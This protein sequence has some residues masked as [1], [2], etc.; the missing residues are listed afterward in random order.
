M[1]KRVL[2]VA[3]DV[4]DNFFHGYGL[5]L[6]T[7]EILKFKLKP[8]LGSLLKK[9]LEMEKKK[10]KLKVCYEA[11]YIGYTLCRD[12][13]KHNIECEIIAPSL[14]PSKPGKRVKTDRIDCKKLAEYYSKG[15]L[16]SIH[17]PDEKDEEV[18][19]MIRARSFLVKQ[20]KNL[21]KHI[22]STCRRYRLN[23]KEAT[24]SKD[25]WT[26]KHIDWLTIQV[27]KM[28]GCIKKTFEI[29][30]YEL[31]KLNEGISD[32]NEE[33]ENMSEDKRY[34]IKKETLNCFRGLDTL[35]SMTLIAEIGDI[36]RFSHPNKLTSYAGLDIREYSS[37]GKEKKYGITK[38][39]NRRI[40][41]T[42]IEA[43]QNIRTASKISKRLRRARKNQDV[44]IIDIADRCQ[45]RLKKKSVRM[46]YAGKPANKIK[47]GC[48]RE[49]LCFVWEALQQVS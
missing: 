28:T 21:K 37:G 27:N 30:L 4:D 5:S 40:R 7:G 34:K 41:T 19:D 17:I 32:L 39:G 3:V 16:T 25:Y 8:T 46:F 10:Y 26:V 42:A 13:K 33:I 15:L 23:Y 6:E 22:L 48:A 45:A 14:V 35:S 20:Q 44:K 36:R 9:L 43:C 29:L 38:I 2:Y 18:R 11:S 47:V 49:M 12:L 24:K 1:K 31:D